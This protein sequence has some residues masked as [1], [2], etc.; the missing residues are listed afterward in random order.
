MTGGAVKELRS[1]LYQGESSGIGELQLGKPVTAIYQYTWSV[2][3]DDLL[4]IEPF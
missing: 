4:K 1:K 3:G 2:E